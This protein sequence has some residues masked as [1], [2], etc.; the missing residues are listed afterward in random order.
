MIE[1]VHKILKENE[2]N[3]QGINNLNNDIILKFKDIKE[4]QERLEI[5]ENSFKEKEFEKE[6]F[7]EDFRI[8]DSVINESLDIINKEEGELNKRELQKAK[9][10]MEMDNLYT[11]L[12]EE[13]DLTLAEAKDIAVEVEDTNALKD[14]ITTLKKKVTSLGIVNLAAIEE[15]EEIKEKYEF[16]SSQ[17]QDLE[18]AEDELLSVIG[19][20]T[21]KMKDFI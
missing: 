13:L 12:N 10:E 6:K 17:Q 3:N 19:E 4:A 18:K 8:K 16:M 14:A 1:R 9:N 11:K 2:E 15:Y 5:L 20:M 21:D 7:K